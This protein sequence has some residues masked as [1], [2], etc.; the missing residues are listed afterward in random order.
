ME[1][2]RLR[3]LQH[4]SQIE[5]LLE[6]LVSRGDLLPKG[7]YR[8]RDPKALSSQLQMIATQ[9]ASEGRIWAS[10]ANTHYI[11]LFTCE[12]SLHL[13]RERGTPVL[14]VNRYDENGELQDTGSWTADAEGKWQRCGD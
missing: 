4:P 12:M 3:N 14:L 10:W 1:T 11:W 2:M 7:S 5:V 8:I 13:S 6:T 9:A